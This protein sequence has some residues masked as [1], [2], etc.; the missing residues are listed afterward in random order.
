MLFDFFQEKLQL[1]TAAAIIDQTTIEAIQFVW[2]T[3]CH[4]DVADEQLDNRVD[5]GD[6]HIWVEIEAAVE[7][8]RETVPDR[9][10]TTYNQQWR[11]NAESGL[12]DANIA[13]GGT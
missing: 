3:K 4:T 5:Y 7:L 2:S 11:V 8:C 13:I 9:D 1:I 12:I 10:Q 6:R